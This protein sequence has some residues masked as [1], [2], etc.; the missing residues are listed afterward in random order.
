MISPVCRPSSSS[1]RLSAFTVLELLVVIAVIGMVLVIGLPSFNEILRGRRVGI[2][3]GQLSNDLRLARQMAITT[4]QPVHIIFPD[5][6][7]HNS[8][9][10]AYRSYAVYAR[11]DG[12]AGSWRIMPAGV[13]FIPTGGVHNVFTTNRLARGVVPDLDV[14]NEG[15]F[16]ITFRSDGSLKVPD[17]VSEG[18]FQSIYIGEGW[19][20][21]NGTMRVRQR[22]NSV[23]YV[24]EIL[25]ASGLVS[26]G[27]L[28]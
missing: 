8:N 4:R 7:V 11:D 14:A 9:A 17:A 16:A 12:Y 1:L 5:V 2:A 3:A 18:Y 19:M 13:L 20:E 10:P 26:G 23:P 21:T 22:E 27:Y 25:S 24:V 6:V 28:K 15:V